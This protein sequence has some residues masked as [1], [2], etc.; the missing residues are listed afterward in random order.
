MIPKFSLAVLCARITSANAGQLQSQSALT[1]ALSALAVAADSA[2]NL[3]VA[4]C[5]AETATACCEFSPELFNVGQPGADVQRLPVFGSPRKSSHLT[6]RLC[7]DQSR[8]W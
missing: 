3:S 5:Y 7:A 4:A 6:A 8:K 2:P 1:G